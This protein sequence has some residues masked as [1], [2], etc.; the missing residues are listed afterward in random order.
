[1]KKGMEYM[2][3]LQELQFAAVEIRLYL[4]T[5]PHDQR[6]QQDYSEITYHIKKIIPHVE[7]YYGPLTQFRYSRENPERWVTEPWPWEY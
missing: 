7:H 2:R 6:A 5:H 1:L 3:K 4:D